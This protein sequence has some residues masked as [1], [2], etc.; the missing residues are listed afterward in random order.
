MEVYRR[1]FSE[2][3]TDS[4]D[5][6]ILEAKMEEIDNWKTHEIFQEVAVKGLCTISVK[7]VVTKKNKS[8]GN[9]Y[10]ARLKVRDCEGVEKDSIWK[11]SSTS[12]K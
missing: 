3:T 5:V 10:K 9:V 12:C 6:Q 2:K 4:D 1:P 8:N 11:D 7:R